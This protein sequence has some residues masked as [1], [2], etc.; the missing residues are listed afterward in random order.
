MLCIYVSVYVS[1]YACTG[2]YRWMI[3]ILPTWRH[4]L[5]TDLSYLFHFLVESLFLAQQAPADLDA[6]RPI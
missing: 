6:K 5:R 1:L 3:E 4:N 2:K